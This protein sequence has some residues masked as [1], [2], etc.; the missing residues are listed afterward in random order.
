[1]NDEQIELL[2]SGLEKVSYLSLRGNVY[3]RLYNHTTRSLD[4]EALHLLEEAVVALYRELLSFLS[5]ALRRFSKSTPRQALSALFKPKDVD[6]RLQRMADCASEADREASNCDRWINLADKDELD[7]VV[8]KERILADTQIESMWVNMASEE[9]GRILAWISAIP[10]VSDH[11]F[12]KKGLVEGTGNWLLERSELH[13]W[14]Q[15][16]QSATFWLHGIRG[17]PLS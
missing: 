10:Y 1:M 15:C 12:A 6:E 16:G 11:E 8:D 17:W 5:L 2:Y 13:E 7:Y 14:H 4:P 3:E 9:R